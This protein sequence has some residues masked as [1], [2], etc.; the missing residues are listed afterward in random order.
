MRAR[1]CWCIESVTVTLLSSMLLVAER[2]DSGINRQ[3]RIRVGVL[4][5]LR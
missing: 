3:V 1:R 2:G 5:R 4:R